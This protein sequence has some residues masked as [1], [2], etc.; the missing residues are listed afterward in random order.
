[1]DSLADC[2]KKHL[3]NKNLVDV[4]PG[5]MKPT[6]TNDRT[7]KAYIAKRIDRFLVHASIIDKFGM[8]H[9][10]MENVLVSDHIPIMLSWMEKGF[11]KGYP[12]KFNR[13][14]LKDP[15]FNELIEKAWKEMSSQ[16]TLPPFLTFRDKIAAM[17]RIVKKWEVRK[18]EKDKMTLTSIQQELDSILKHA[19]ANSLSFSMKCSIRDLERKKFELLKQEESFWRLKSRATWLQEG[20]KNTKFFHKFASARHDK[21]SI[22][23]VKNENGDS[24]VSQKDI[25]REAVNYFRKQYNRRSDAAFQDILWGIDQVP[26]MFNEDAN[27]MLFKPVTEEELF[28]VLKTFKKEKSPGSDGWTIEFLTHFFE[29]IKHDL[30]RMVEASRMSGNIHHITS[31]TLITLIPKKL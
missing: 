1:M 23:K 27:E 29:L 5:E 9:S 30:L 20:N 24:F 16:A 12:F 19:N 7:D 31:S 4:V 22:W 15:A 3:L 13:S 2:I 21:N 6:W 14:F 8:P 26:Q 25:T 11:K 18:K 17:R 10:T 28:G